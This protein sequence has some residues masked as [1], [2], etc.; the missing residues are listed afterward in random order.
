MK[1]VPKKRE[2]QGFLSFAG[3]AGL[4]FGLR[5]GLL[6]CNPSV[7]LQVSNDAASFVVKVPGSCE[8][9]PEIGG[10]TL[11]GKALCLRFPTTTGFVW[12]CTMCLFRHGISS[13]SLQF[14]F[15]DSG[16]GLKQTQSSIPGD[17]LQICFKFAQ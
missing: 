7:V 5:C 15:T 14:R 9:T 16:R 3:F 10:P 11:A 17:P 8:R 6:G 12:F 2:K 4:G 13:F 1:P